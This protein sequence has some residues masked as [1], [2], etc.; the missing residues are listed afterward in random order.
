[1]LAARPTLVSGLDGLREAVRGY[2]CAVVV[3]PGR[4]A[5]WADAVQRVVADWP[6]YR[7]AAAA[8]AALAA[9]RH[10]P[11][12]YRS[13]LRDAVRGRAPRPVAVPT[14]RTP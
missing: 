7:A 10:A 5:E 9:E 11:E 2:G 3:P 12:R 13:T 6:R 1:V 8:D 4:A 14:R